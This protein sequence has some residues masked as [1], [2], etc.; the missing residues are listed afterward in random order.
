MA[1]AVRNAVKKSSSTATSPGKKKFGERESLATEK[2]L[3]TDG[4]VVCGVHG[5]SIARVSEALWNARVRVLARP[6]G[7]GAATPRARSLRV[8]R[9]AEG[10]KVT[11]DRRTTVNFKVLRAF[12]KVARKMGASKWVIDAINNNPTNADP[13]LGG[14]VPVVARVAAYGNGIE[15]I[16]NSVG[17]QPFTVSRT[18]LSTAAV[19]LGLVPVGKEFQSPTAAGTYSVEVTNEFGCK[20][21]ALHT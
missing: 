5:R 4:E 9:H 13:M 2:L 19:D 6:A 10:W 21:S 3:E 8:G 17:T 16:D 1:S 14:G 15:L 11:F 18:T 20:A 7:Q 12:L